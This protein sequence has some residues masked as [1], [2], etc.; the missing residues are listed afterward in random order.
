MSDN[1]ELNK[2]PSIKSETRNGSGSDNSPGRGCLYAL[3]WVFIIFKLWSKKGWED[4]GFFLSDFWKHPEDFAPTAGTLFLIWTIF[5]IILVIVGTFGFLHFINNIHKKLKNSSKWKDSLGT[6]S[7]VERVA[8]LLKAAAL[9]LTPSVILEELVNKRNAVLNSMIYAFVAIGIQYS[10]FE[11]LKIPPETDTAA[12]ALY[13]YEL[14]LIPDAKTHTIRDSVLSNVLNFLERKSKFESTYKEDVKNA[15]YLR[16]R[17]T[18]LYHADAEYIRE[19]LGNT[20]DL[21]MLLEFSYHIRTVDDLED[22]VKSLP[23]DLKLSFLESLQK[24]EWY[25]HLLDMLVYIIVILV[26]AVLFALLKKDGSYSF[27]RSFIACACMIASLSILST[28]IFGLMYFV[29]LTIVA[30]IVTILALFISFEVWML[31]I[32]PRFLS[33]KSWKTFLI[34]NVAFGIVQAV[35]FI[36]LYNLLGGI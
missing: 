10:I 13:N 6:L 29:T 31:R 17:Q 20:S 36:F 28:L 4:L 9:V 18:R 7:E 22:A 35:G 30:R 5:K 26:I 24:K 8:N 12:T 34:G 25:D 33:V 15:L 27:K 32:I 19:F 2:Q 11:G 3:V 1:I 16:I 14:H 23:S 21:Q